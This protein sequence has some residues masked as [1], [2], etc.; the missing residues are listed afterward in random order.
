MAAAEFAEVGWKESCSVSSKGSHQIG[1]NGCASA[2]CGRADSQRS[3]LRDAPGTVDRWRRHPSHKSGSFS[4]FVSM[5]AL[6]GW[7]WPQSSRFSRCND[8]AGGQ[9]I[10]HITTPRQLSQ[11][12]RS[13]REAVR[14]GA[15]AIDLVDGDSICDLLKKMRLGV[16]V[17]N[18]EVVEVHPEQLTG[19]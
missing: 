2:F 15:P 9:R 16:G 6:E 13:R 8:W 12:K 14:D 18:V 11:L 1:S 5:Q 3:R 10:D 17:R 4:R 19:I 7:V